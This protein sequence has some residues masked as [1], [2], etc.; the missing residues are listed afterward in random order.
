MGPTGDRGGARPF[1]AAY[2]SPPFVNTLER[3]L[4]FFEH[5]TLEMPGDM[6]TLWESFQTEPGCDERRWALSLNDV[7]P[8]PLE[9]VKAAEYLVYEESRWSDWRKVDSL[10]HVSMTLDRYNEP[11]GLIEAPT[12]PKLWTAAQIARELVGD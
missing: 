8:E 1:T 10:I 6:V 4:R 5:G 11:A 7:P 3:A 2:S 9:G 12:G